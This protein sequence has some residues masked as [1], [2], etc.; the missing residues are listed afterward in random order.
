M[1][2]DRGYISPYFINTSKGQKCGFQDAY[3]LL[4]EKKISS[5]QSIVLALE[6]ANATQKPFVTTAEDMD[7]KA[8]SMLVLNRLKVGLQVVTVKAPGFGDN[9]KNQLK[10]M[11]IATD[12]AKKS[13]KAQIEKC[14]QEITEQ[15]DITTSEYEKEKLNEGLA[16][17]S[18][19]VAVLKVGG[20]S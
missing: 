12:D 18:D 20:T 11:A 16:K 13:D 6:I 9:R 7:V 8:L 10:D 5:V 4:S 2:L 3:V 1:K 15:L 19:G 14:I 17:L